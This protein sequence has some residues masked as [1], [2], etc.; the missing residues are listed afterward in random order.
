MAPVGFTGE[1]VGLQPQP[2]QIWPEHGCE[3]PG[4]DQDARP[5]LGGDAKKVLLRLVVRKGVIKT[6][7]S[8]RSA[9]KILRPKMVAGKP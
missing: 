2:A 1:G 7:W 3:Q 5:R 8:D 6:G 4:N 9:Q